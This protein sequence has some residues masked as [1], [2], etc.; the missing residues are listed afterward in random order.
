MTVVVCPSFKSVGDAIDYL[1]R[2]GCRAFYLWRGPDG[3]V[4]GHGTKWNH[5]DGMPSP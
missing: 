1:E 2:A 4:R 3:L 5:V